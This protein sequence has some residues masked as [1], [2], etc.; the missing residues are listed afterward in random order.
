MGAKK[1]DEEKQVT[2][3]A[4]NT[5]R[6]EKTAAAK[7]VAKTVK[8]DERTHPLSAAVGGGRWFK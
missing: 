6:R 1:T 3:D 7:T 5:R 4:R 8:K 2:S